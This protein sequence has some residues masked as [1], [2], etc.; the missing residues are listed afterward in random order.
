MI[1]PAHRMKQKKKIIFYI[2]TGMSGAGKSHAIN[3]LEDIGFFCVD[4]LPVTLLPKFGELALKLG[5]KLTRVA[6]GIDIR[7]GRLLDELKPA[8]TKLKRS[9]IDTKII[10]FDADNTT[11]LRRYSETRRKHPLG[12]RVLEGL[13]KERF[14]LQ[15]IKSYA[16]RICDTSNLT[17]SELREILITWMSGKDYDDLNV[18][19]M[20]FGF[21][22]GLPPDADIIM[23]VRIL[24]NPNYIRPLKNLSGKDRKVKEFVMRQKATRGFLKAFSNL[25]SLMLPRFVDE[26]KSY[27]TV[28]LGCTGGRH[29]SVVMAGKIAGFLASRGYPARVLHRDIDR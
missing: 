17:L 2:I 18:T 19:V 10:F 4:N 26:G 16:D 15:E 5:G 6:V 7:V 1:K 20:S 9:G 22:F 23:D 21:K 11:L 3:C 24:P 25:L 14:L 13:K 27:L 8:L 12:K 29:R 28:A